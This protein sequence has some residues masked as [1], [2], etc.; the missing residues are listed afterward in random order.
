MLNKSEIKR[1]KKTKSLEV[2]VDGGLNWEQHFKIVIGKVRG[3]L[4]SLKKTEKP[5]ATKTT[6]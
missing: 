2:I 5:D 6:R 4:A 3:G 1:A